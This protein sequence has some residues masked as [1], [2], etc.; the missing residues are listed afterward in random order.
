MKASA[1]Q[2]EPATPARIH[3]RIKHPQLDPAE[4]TR[5]LE[6]TPE[7]TFEAGR[8]A[9]AE[10][11][12]RLHADCYWIAPLSFPSFEQPWML[13]RSKAPLPDRLANV[14][15][16]QMMS[17]EEVLSLALRQLQIHQAFFQKISE[18]GGTATL[19]IN[20]DEPGSL[21]IRPTLAR[22]LADTGLCLELDWAGGVD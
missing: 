5:T 12:E 14:T 2:R 7:H 21:M 6:I 8:S 11:I 4:I 15:A 10:G 13:G 17:H 9:S 22:K 20:L 1:R 18:E 19:L 3:L 16:L